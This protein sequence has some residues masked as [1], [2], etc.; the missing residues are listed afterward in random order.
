MFMN[1]CDSDVDGFQL[2]GCE[3]VSTIAVRSTVTFVIKY[4]MGIVCKVREG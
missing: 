4:G 3:L 1:F 2:K